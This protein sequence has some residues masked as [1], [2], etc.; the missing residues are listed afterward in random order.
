MRCILCIEGKEHTSTTCNR[1]CWIE[2][3]RERV[4]REYP[5]FCDINGFVAASMRM[6]PPKRK[7]PRVLPKGKR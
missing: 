2:S 4:R 5:A 6:D 1:L 3:E 7:A